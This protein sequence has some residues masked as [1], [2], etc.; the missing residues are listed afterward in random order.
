MTAWCFR[1]VTLLLALAAAPSLAQTTHIQPRLVAESSAPR[2]GTMVALAIDMKT[3]NGWHGYW[4]NPGE[5][6]FAPR[7]K[8]TLP[9]G[10]SIG[11]PAYPVPQTL[12][13]ASLMNYVFEADHALILPLKIPAAMTTG[14][15]IAIHLDAE[16]L[17]CT[18]QVCVPETGSFDLVL[19]AGDGARDNG[20]LFD[21]W[22]AKLPKPLGGTA[23]FEA[24]SD[25]IRLA[26]PFP[27]TAQLGDPHF[28]PLG[29]GMIVD[30]APQSFS[31]NGDMLIVSLARSKESLVPVRGI[32]ALGNG[33][34]LSI[35]AKPGPVPPDGKPLGNAAAMPQWRVIL[36]ALGGAILGGLILNIMPC[37]FPIVS[38]KA[39]GLARAGGDERAAK[40][41]ALAY[42]GGVILTCLALGGVILAVRAG[43]GQLGWAFQLQDQRMVFLLLALATVITLNL[44]GL[45]ELRALGAGQTLAE[46][47]GTSGA[48]W[49]GVLAA[50]VAT[51]C[52][53]PF[54]AA[55]LGAALILPVP[56]AL[57]VFAGLGLGLAL[58]FLAV[59]FVPGL[60]RLLPKP[61]AWMIRFQ[62]ALAVPMA[63]TVVA[64]L[65]LVDRQSG[66]AGFQF[67]LLTV[68]GLA[69]IAWLTGRSQK[70]VP[71]RSALS[72]LAILLIGGVALIKAEAISASTPAAAAIPFSEKRLAALRAEGRPVFVYFTADWCLTCKVNEKTA[73]ESAAV[74]DAFREAG[75]AVLVGDWTNGDAAITRVLNAN[76]VNGVPLYLY[77]TPG[78]SE[79]ERLPQVLTPATL[80][81]LTSA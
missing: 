62:R 33:T 39:L 30:A 45:Y 50:F 1:F 48:F 51:P 46:K 28:F 2:R 40:G 72:L 21:A 10:V 35:D 9:A 60:R 3:E 68:A 18:D 17:A 15:P 78:K 13:I 7:L 59:G 47:P 65:W 16:W 19:K 77:Y 22:M 42:A 23:T 34:G 12:T 11:D 24:T 26:I 67:A 80:T 49:T 56:A 27:A 81:A 8:W 36:L 71:S 54:M 20:A 73:L 31:R 43:G 61:G 41:E 38:L 74:R 79:P 55:A 75:V 37:V 70:V 6:G 44:A 63:L 4:S 53:G 64:L 58:P 32:F 76:G 29:A 57:A 69:A 25:R 66:P 5:A 14:A 52:T